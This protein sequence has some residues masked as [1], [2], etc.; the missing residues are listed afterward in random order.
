LSCISQKRHLQEENS[1]LMFDSVFTAHF[2]K[3]FP[4]KNDRSITPIATI[5]RKMGRVETGGKAL[6]QKELHAAALQ[7]VKTLDKAIAK[8]DLGAINKFQWSAVPALSK[9]LWGVWVSAWNLGGEHADGELNKKTK[10]LTRFSNDQ[11]NIVYFDGEQENVR[12]ASIRNTPAEN[13]IRERVNKLASDVS[14]SEWQRIKSHIIDSIS[15]PAGQENPISRTEL[16]SRINTELG[17][18]A[19][20]FANRAEGIARTET[21]FAYNAGRL[22]T[23]QRS[24]LVYAVQYMAISDDRTCEIC[25]SC[26]G[27]VVLLSDVAAIAR[28]MPPRHSRCRCVITGLLDTPGDREQADD[29]DNL[30]ENRT[31]VPSPPAWA[32]AAILAALLVGGI[33]AA[34]S[35]RSRIGQIAREIGEVGVGVAGTAAAADAVARINRGQ[36]PDADEV[37][38]EPTEP[39]PTG[40][41]PG[42][43]VEDVVPV[44]KIVSVKPQVTVGGIDLNTATFDEI[45]ALLPRRL[46]KVDQIKELIKWRDQFPID[47]LN[48]L[49]KIP[50]IGKR[51]GDALKS[52][53]QGL[54]VV[55]D[56]NNVR[57]WQQLWASNAGLS[58]K[59]AQALFE[60]IKRNPLESIEDLQSRQIP[61]VGEKSIDELIKRSFITRQSIKQRQKQTQVQTVGGEASTPTPQGASRSEALERGKRKQP[62]QDEPPSDGDGDGSGGS[63]MPSPRTP[64][65]YSG[66]GSGRIDPISSPTPPRQPPRTSTAPPAPPIDPA[67]QQALLNLEKKLNYL[68]GQAAGLDADLFNEM[69]KKR[70]F[71]KSPN[72][73]HDEVQAQATGIKNESSSIEAEL[74]TTA[75]SINSLG[76]RADRMERVFEGITDPAAPNYFERVPQALSSAKAELRRVTSS[77]DKAVSDI[78]KA[79]SSID[80]ST[81]SLDSAIRQSSTKKIQELEQGLEDINSS[82]E[83]WDNLARQL[84]DLEEDGSD[85]LS[86]LQQLRDKH[87]TIQT[88]LAQSTANT[89]TQYASTL[90][91]VGDL[92]DELNGLRSQL[93][94]TQSQSRK[95]QQRLDNLPTTRQQLDPATRAS[96][97]SSVKVRQLQRQFTKDLQTFRSADRQVQQNLQQ[98]SQNQLDFYNRYDQQFINYEQS[99]SPLIERRLQMMESSIKSL[100][101]YPPGVTAWLLEFGNKWQFEAVPGDLALALRGLSKNEQVERV[102]QLTREVQQHYNQIAQSSKL[103]R[104]N[105]EFRYLEGGQRFSPDKVLKRS[106]SN[107]NYWQRQANDLVSPENIGSTS[108]R[109]D[110]L[111]KGTVSPEPNDTLGL[112]R[113]I[114][115]NLDEWST[116]YQDLAQDLTATAPEI[117]PRNNLQEQLSRAR[118]SFLQEAGQSRVN[119]SQIVNEALEEAKDIYQRVRVDKSRVPT[120]EV[121]GKTASAS[122]IL[123]QVEG[124][125]EQAKQFKQMSEITAEPIPAIPGNAPQIQKLAGQRDSLTSQLDSVSDQLVETQSQL[126]QARIAGRGTK[127]LEKS[128]GELERQQLDLQNQVNDAVNEIRDLR[129]PAETYNQIQDLKAQV[130]QRYQSRDK[131]SQE[132]ADTVKELTP[133]LEQ[134][135]E[136]LSQTAE[137]RRSRIASLSDKRDRLTQGI[138]K[139]NQQIN[140][141]AMQVDQLRNSST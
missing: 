91:G 27:L 86:Q 50:K 15:P 138:I 127:R 32:T 58:K 84:E 31:I 115:Q 118:E 81:A 87:Q 43:I 96:Y 2:Q 95:L 77:T 111:A 101:G 37:P 3:N 46:L 133:L 70:P 134:G 28:I 23:Y 5:T 73:I 71:G 89:R 121:G 51:T 119:Q 47:D 92:K 57:T 59:Q 120:F 78:D 122:D 80:K 103:I 97:D 106:E 7:A 36:Q 137:R 18:K 116:R 82:L 41:A 62:K 90:Q 105:S 44:S 130:R 107:L 40:G 45:A 124:Y 53:A 65:P 85:Y 34:S 52:L 140:Q 83:E 99:A 75:S 8:K 48:D 14:N 131:L 117:V 10:Q 100:Q 69:S 56:L 4:F 94:N 19:N 49:Y 63:P 110:N 22:D 113:R 6:L 64:S 55:T 104:E 60:E 102:R 125:E 112:S 66:G 88:K 76:Q 39:E 12:R 33:S 109:I 1:F 26:N 38:V 11:N 9:A 61:G 79:L 72:Q 13:A 25:L 108:N 30:E 54:D 123:K 42:E 68:D 129:L 29:P 139:V 141:L 16:I 20:R 35:M 17:G 136:G 128:V 93:T 114:V 67:R 126:E 132:L 21:T 98:Y 24:G 74:N 135:S